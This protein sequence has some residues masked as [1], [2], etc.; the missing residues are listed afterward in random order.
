ML[1]PSAAVT[2]SLKSAHRQHRV[3]AFAAEVPGIKHHGDHTRLLLRV[4]F[5]TIV[6][7]TVTVYLPYLIVSRWRPVR[8]ESW[9]I[10]QGLA[11]RKTGFFSLFRRDRDDL[12]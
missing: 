6:P 1:S 7:G 5:W 11:E 10:V 12:S 9:R 4:V 8:L 2:S 3:C